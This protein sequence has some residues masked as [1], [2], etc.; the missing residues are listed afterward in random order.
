MTLFLLGLAIFFGPHFYSALRSRDPDSDL[1][2]RMGEGPYMGTYSLVSLL[3]F[4]LIIYGFGASRGA[5]VLYT[6]PIWTQ[7]LNLVLMIIALILLV[8]S[9]LPAGHIKKTMKHPMLVA[10]KVW[11]IGHLLANGEL[12]SVILFGSFLAF[13][14]LDRIIV[15]KRDD[16]G[17][18]PDRE[19]NHVMDGVSVVVGLA[20]WAALAFWLHPILFG[21]RVIA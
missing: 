13:D 21:V 19:M 18:G 5:G 16:N 11:A 8:A 2:K 12:N 3:G 7:H 1:R 15:K 20:V 14:V 9:Q 10:V 6:P 4:G 17:K